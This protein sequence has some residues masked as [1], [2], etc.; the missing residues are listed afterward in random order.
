MHNLFC[1]LKLYW[2]V[3][4]TH[5]KQNKMNSYKFLELFF[6]N[7]RGCGKPQEGSEK[8]VKGNQKEEASDIRG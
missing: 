5:Y 4:K 7:Y 6:G 1:D 3:Q 8:L 2:N